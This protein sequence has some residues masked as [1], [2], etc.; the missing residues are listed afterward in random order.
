VVC[1]EV[2]GKILREQHGEVAIP[3]GSEYTI[4][5]KNLNS[6]RAQARISIDGDDITD[7]WLII[8]ANSKLNL[9][10][11]IK[12][13][14]LSQGNRFKFIERTAEI[15]QHR[16]IGDSDG[17]IRVEFKFEKMQT[18]APTSAT[19]I[20]TSNLPNWSY[21][22]TGQKI[23]AGNILRS[24]TIN[25]SS[26]L[27]PSSTEEKVGITVPG[28]ISSQSFVNAS[29]F[30]CEN[31]EV[32]VIKLVGKFGTMNV[33]KPVTVDIKPKCITC[34]RTNRATNRFCSTCGTSLLV[35]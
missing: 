22:S 28:G 5:L 17:L 1:I 32:L 30:A 3:F 11:S 26:V 35:I 23:A 6:V 18:W 20:T 16:G 33:S 19:Y 29:D 4:L 8:E 27:T 14:N 31:S 10:R 12:N 7:G 15:E 34:G 25:C 24:A 21:T 2:N 13:R 9:E